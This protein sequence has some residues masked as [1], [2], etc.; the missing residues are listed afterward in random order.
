MQF[1]SF[2]SMGW[3]LSSQWI[4]YGCGKSYINFVR[5]IGRSNPF[6]NGLELAYVYILYM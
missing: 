6:R 3:I 4:G 1:A 2:L 5:G